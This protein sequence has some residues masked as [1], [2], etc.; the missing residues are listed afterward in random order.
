MNPEQEMEAAAKLAAACEH[1]AGEHGTCVFCGA[2]K[3]DLDDV[4]E[5][6]MRRT[7]LFSH[8]QESLIPSTHEPLVGDLSSID[9]ANAYLMLMSFCAGLLLQTIGERQLRGEFES[10]IADA[11]HKVGMSFKP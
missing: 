10:I 4:W 5:A 6:P 1:E 11:R 2:L 7:R 8:T 9:A 3:T